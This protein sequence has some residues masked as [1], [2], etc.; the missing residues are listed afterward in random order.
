[1]NNLPGAI[2]QTIP[3]ERPRCRKVIIENGLRPHLVNGKWD[4]RFCLCPDGSEA[5]MSIGLR[6]QMRRMIEDGYWR[7]SVT[8]VDSSSGE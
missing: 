2:S 8:P 4:H 1:M 6:K 7:E 3:K 5:Y